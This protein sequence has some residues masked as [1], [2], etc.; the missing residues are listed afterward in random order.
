MLLSQ[1][2]DL[3]SDVIEFLRRLHQYWNWQHI[4]TQP[5]YGESVKDFGHEV[6][7]S[8]SGDRYT[9]PSNIELEVA[10]CLGGNRGT[11]CKHGEA[12]DHN[13]VIK[14]NVYPDIILVNK[15]GE[16]LVGVEVKAWNIICSANP[17]N[18]WGSMCAKD[19]DNKNDILVVVPW[20]LKK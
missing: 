5:I 4:Q 18:S 15:K 11:W 13:L 12:N 14:S 2:P 3:V 7:S 19:T 6:A 8:S 1:K 9:L 17:E 20:Y 16:Q 10:K